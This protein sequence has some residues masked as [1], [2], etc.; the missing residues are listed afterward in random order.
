MLNLYYIFWIIFGLLILIFFFFKFF[1]NFFKANGFKSFYKVL[2][3]KDNKFLL[4]ILLIFTIIFWSSFYLLFY[5][6]SYPSLRITEH[7]GNNEINITSCI[8]DDCNNLSIDYQDEISLD[9]V[10]YSRDYLTFKLNKPMYLKEC[11]NCNLNILYKNKEYKLKLNDSIFLE[12][13][14][15]N[16]NNNVY[17]VI[18]LNK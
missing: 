11:E 6:K 8:L 16:L 2:F 13:I 4:L 15:N 14:D 9:I 10:D 5:L 17:Y 3:K 12:E 18:D 7:L 1:T